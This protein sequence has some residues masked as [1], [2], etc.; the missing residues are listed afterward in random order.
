MPGGEDAMREE[1]RTVIKRQT[2]AKGRSRWFW[3]RVDTVTLLGEAIR[4]KAIRETMKPR[5]AS[6]RSEAFLSWRLDQ[7]ETLDLT[8]HTAAGRG[9]AT[10]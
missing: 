2:S 6:C 10:H 1:K 8:T 9:D 5:L 3:N 4:D 7:H